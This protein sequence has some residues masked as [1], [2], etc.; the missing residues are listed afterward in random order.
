MDAY[1]AP[2]D[3][4]LADA[5]DAL[6]SPE[7]LTVGQVTGHA[8]AVFAE[9]LRDRKNARRIPHRFEECGYVAVRNPGDTEGR[10]K[11][12]GRRHT[13]YAKA[14]LSIHDRAAAAN[15]LAGAR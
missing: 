1:R 3:D 2:E 14:R 7:A 13:I 11:I 6:G 8:V 5:I 4:E 15:R 12:D 9:W 10:W